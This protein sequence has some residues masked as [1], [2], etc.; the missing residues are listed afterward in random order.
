MRDRVYVGGTFD[1]FHAGHVELLRKA[2]ELG[3]V[4]VSLNTDEFAE[5]YK[6]RPILTLEERRAV[7]RACE[8]VAHC[9]INVG[10][11]NSWPAISIASPRY[12]VHGDDWTG[13]SFLQ[14]LGVAPEW[15]EKRGIELV[16]LPYTEGISS[17]EIERRVI[18]RDLHGCRDCTCRKPAPDSGQPALPDTKAGRDSRLCKRSGSGCPC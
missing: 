3:D 11:E 7:V 12:I 9:I 1:L 13:E 5:R 6:R 2:S 8:H 17:T 10:G 15:L 14:Q 16:Y 4:W 18:E